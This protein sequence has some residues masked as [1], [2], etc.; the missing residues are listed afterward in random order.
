[1]CAASDLYLQSIAT[2]TAHPMI[3][4]GKLY[5]WHCCQ[6]FSQESLLLAVQKVAK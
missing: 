4:V 2:L 5:G 1:M 3:V 6:L